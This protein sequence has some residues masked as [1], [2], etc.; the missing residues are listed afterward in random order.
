MTPSPLDEVE[1]LIRSSHPLIVLDAEED[2][3]A[4][5]LV[6]RALSG[7]GHAY[8][9][10]NAAHGLRREGEA[11]A[12][13]GTSKLDACLE[14]IGSSSLS[15][16]VYHLQGAT[17]LF[18][19]LHRSARLVAL[20]EGLGRLR[21]AVLFT[22][23]ASQLP[24][25]LRRRAAVIPLRPPDDHEYFQFVNAILAD[26]RTRMPVR[27]QMTPTDS[28]R[29]IGHLR[30]LS[31]H[32]VRKVITQAIVRD[33]TLDPSDLDF[34]SSR[35]R[36]IVEQSGVLEYF[37][38]AA[39]LGDIAGLTQLK[40]W[41]AARAPV[42]HAPEAARDFG[43]SPPRGLLLLGV[44]GCGKSLCAKAVAN[45]W[46]LPLLRLD[47]ARIY[48][49]Y[50]GETERNLHRAMTLAE[51]MSPIVL[52][53]DE[54]EKIFGG[55]QRDESG[56]SQRVL[57]AFLTWLQE[58]RAS[59]FVI[60]TANDVSSLP[61]E[62]IRKGRFDE[63]FFVDLPGEPHRRD[64]LAIHL[65]R[66]RRDP[67]QYDLQALAEASEGFSGAELE[68]AV[69]GA[70]YSAFAEGSELTDR[71]LLEELRRTRPL[72]VTMAEP[73]ARLRAWASSRTTPAD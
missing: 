21:S 47:T 58:K 54:L 67:K 39:D 56:A 26:V 64:I 52:W 62:L 51:R 15:D 42:F 46:S 48:S 2:D 18:D 6:A 38:T 45:A 33:G 5:S 29:L 25:T 72:S 59:V 44:Q 8:F 9:R 40:R 4:L 63:I 71:H 32:E 30:G 55:G 31:F 22:G 68:Q 69:V 11:Q 61:P 17:E 43:L 34:I 37:P 28:S 10:W 1:L 36:E 12:L 41:L 70:L 14:H 60:A 16:A 65:G 53:I 24:E 73:I 35:K 23:P 13:Y 20:A 57:S 50:F 7:L 3:R 66:R 49:K 19:D 27:M